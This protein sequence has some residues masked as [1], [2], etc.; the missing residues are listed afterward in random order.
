MTAKEIRNKTLKDNS[1]AKI[2]VCALEQRKSLVSLSHQNNEFALQERVTFKRERVVVS[3]TLKQLVLKELHAGH[4]G[5]VKMK[6]SS[7][8]FCW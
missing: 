8:N 2:I 3:K 5:C 7:I 4:F 1:L 6:N